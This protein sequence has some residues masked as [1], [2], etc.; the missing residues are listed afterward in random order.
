MKLI[1]NAHYLEVLATTSQSFHERYYAMY[2]SILDGV[3]LDPLLMQVPVD[4]HL[5]HRGDGVFDT[6]KCVARGAYNLEPH[7]KRLVRSAGEIGLVWPGGLEDLRSKTVETLKCADKDACSVRVILA[8]GPG[9]LGVSPY[10]SPRP[11]LY[12]VVYAAGTPFMKMHPEG[13]RVK[14]SAIPVKAGNFAT[15]KHCNYLSNVLMKREAVDADVDFVVSYDSQGFLAE[16]A[17]E[18]VGIVTQERELLLPTMEHVLEGTTMVRVMELARGLVAEGLLKR[19]AF[20]DIT[21][22]MVVSATEMLVIGTT[23]NVASTASYEGHRV[24]VECPGPIG[25]RLD[26]L[27]EQ[28]ILGN[29]AMRTGY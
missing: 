1:D 16:G 19:V 28:D 9:G 14:R 27:L 20:A 6:F 17:T 21:E 15:F 18:N 26:A 13:A 5:V 2:S 11:S 10:E 12:I 23:L 3:V 7:L 29:Q 4:D 8:R 25:K 22:A 24:G